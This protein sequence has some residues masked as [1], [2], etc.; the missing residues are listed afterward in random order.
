MNEARKKRSNVYQEYLASKHKKYIVP[1]I[2]WNNLFSLFQLTQ[3]MWLPVLK[4]LS[5]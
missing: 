5:E 4:R 1:D 2:K 3:E